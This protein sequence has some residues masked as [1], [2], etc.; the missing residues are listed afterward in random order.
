M[1]AKVTIPSLLEKSIGLF[2][3]TRCDFAC[4]ITIP[5]NF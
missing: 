3:Q 4:R 2:S 5:A 1:D